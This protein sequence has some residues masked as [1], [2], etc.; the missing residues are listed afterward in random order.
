MR[1]ILT[2]LAAGFAPPVQAS[3]KPN[4]VV[5]DQHRATRATV[6]QHRLSW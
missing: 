5:C 6:S 2:L 4:V 1:A 3:E